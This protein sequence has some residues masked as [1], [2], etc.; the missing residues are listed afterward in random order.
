MAEVWDNSFR[1]RPAGG[2][3]RSFRTWDELADHTSRVL[4]RRTSL[5]DLRQILGAAPGH[6]DVQWRQRANGGWDMALRLGRRE[7]VDLREAFGR[8]REEMPEAE[9]PPHPA[10]PQ[11]VRRGHLALPATPIRPAPDAASV[12]S[13][14]LSPPGERDAPPGDAPVGLTPR[15]LR[16]EGDPIPEPGGIDPRQLEGLPPHLVRSVMQRRAT[17]ASARSA[18]AGAGG[19]SRPPRAFESPIRWPM[20]QLFQFVVGQ[21]LTQ[22]R[23]RAVP[24]SRLVDELIGQGAADRREHAIRALRELVNRLPRDFRIVQREGVEWFHCDRLR[25]QS[26]VERE[27]M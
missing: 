8:V 3:R 15:R 26:E 16:F 21:F 5:R 25:N 19:A 23:R 13:S 2:T 14:R 4:R 18:S 22:H 17:T 1:L 24:L 9:L 10:T 7:R 6:Y 12:G 11:L 27:L 20:T